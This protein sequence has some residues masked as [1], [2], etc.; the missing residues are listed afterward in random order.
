MRIL[1]YGSLNIDHVYQVRRLVAEG[2]TI[3]AESF[4]SFCGGKGLNQSIALARAGAEVCHAGMVGADGEPLLALLESCGVDTDCISQVPGPTGHALIQVDSC[5]RNSIVVCGGA[6]DAL[7]EE[8]AEAVFRRFSPGDFVLLQ[9]EIAGLPLL[10]RRARQQG[11]RIFLNP[12][13]APQEEVPYELADGLFINETEGAV[14]SGQED[15]TDV[16]KVL[17]RRYPDCEIVLTLGERGSCY[18]GAEGFFLQ[19]AY[20]AEVVDTTAAGD[21]FCGFFLAERS[22]GVPAPQALETASKASSLCVARRGAAPSIPTL[23]EVR[24]FPS[25]RRPLPSAEGLMIR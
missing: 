25:D 4:A 7:T 21:T 1:N 2:E 19:G 12:S 10:L 17:R 6:N 8:R 22:R 5:G 18:A 16:L 11:M 3:R 20:P 23:E 15:P 24:E 13:P 14:L 9:N